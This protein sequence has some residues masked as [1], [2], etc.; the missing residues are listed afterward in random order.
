MASTTVPDAL[1]EALEHAKVP[2]NSTGR[3]LLMLSGGLDSTALLTALLEHTTHKVHAHHIELR[4]REG[5]APAESRAIERVYEWCSRHRREFEHSESTNDFPLGIGG[6]WD[7]TLS[8]FMAARVCYSLRHQVQLVVTGHIQ[9]GFGELTEGEAVFH[10]AF[11]HRVR[12]PRWVRPLAFVA[13]TQAERKAIIR[14][15]MPPELVEAAWW[16]R[17]PTGEH[18]DQPCGECHACKGMVEAAEVSR[19]E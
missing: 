19:D 10:A 16:C 2:A 11:I 12:R 6:G 18:R 1:H 8:M 5:R 17:R 14:D 3:T 4:N 9:P 15:S 13:G 7:T